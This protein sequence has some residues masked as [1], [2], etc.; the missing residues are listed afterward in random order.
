MR[1]TD[2]KR[3][4]ILEAAVTEFERDGFTGASMNRIASTAKV[5]KRTVYNHFESK[6]SLFQAIVAHMLEQMEGLRRME[7]ASDEPMRD[8]LNRLGM[9]FGELASSRDL[10][11]FARVVTSRFIQSPEIASTTLNLR[12]VAQSG[13][14]HWM[15]CAR[16]D[17][18]LNTAN[19]S[20]VAR[21]FTGI[22][23]EFCFWPQLIA[24][25][26]SLSHREL[27]ATV[28]AATELILNTYS[29]ED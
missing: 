1:L 2:R 9:Q 26:P 11:R 24:S 15:Q 4:A 5:S 28:K 27:K 8:Q 29:L 14:A 16:K 3:L 12:E 22:I 19:V 23:Q 17:K 25:E 13:I 7:Y 20:R 21:Q 18:R 10:Q 6:E